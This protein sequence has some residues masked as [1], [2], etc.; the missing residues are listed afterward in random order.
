MSRGVQATLEGGGGED[1]DRPQSLWDDL[2]PAN[3]LILGLV[4]SRTAGS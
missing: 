1:T 2:G 3:T 4:P